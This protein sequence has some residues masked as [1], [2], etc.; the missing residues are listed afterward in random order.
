MYLYLSSSS[1]R[2]KMVLELLKENIVIP[3]MLESFYYI[4]PFQIPYMKHCK[5][6]MLDSGAFTFLKSGKNITKDKIDLFVNKYIDFINE[7]DVNLFFEMDIDNLIGLS[8]VEKIRQKIEDRTKKKTI[9]VFHTSRGKQYYL[10]LVRE[11][12]YIALGGLA[13]TKSKKL[14]NSIPWFIKEAKKANCKLHGLGFTALSK[15]Q[16]PQYHFYS[17]DSSTWV[18]GVRFHNYFKFDGYKM[19][20]NN[21]NTKF[22]KNN[23]E[24]TR[25]NLKEW[26]KYSIYLNKAY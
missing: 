15:L 25:N 21:L 9:P 14:I 17:V 19:I 6:F 16:L 12:E 7:N 24:I 18:H 22:K 20:R 3:Y 4:K 5:L 1:T 11:Y 10:D 8:E 13:L 23:F 2:E 26:I